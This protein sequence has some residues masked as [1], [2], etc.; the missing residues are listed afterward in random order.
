PDSTHVRH[1]MDALDFLVVQDLFLTETARYADVVLPAVSWAEKEGTFVNTERR[2]QKV[3]RALRPRG[4]AR[5][6]WQI[7]TDLANK[8]G[9]N[10]QY[11]CPEDIFREITSLTPSFAGITYD[12][13]GI[14]GI[15]WPCPTEIHP[16]TP[17]LH[18]DK[19]SRGQ[20][21]FSAVEHRD[22]A[23]LPDAEYPFMLTT[24]RILYHYHTG[25][26]TR[27]STGL[28]NVLDEELMEMHPD[29][30]K[31]LGVQECDLVKVTSRRGSVRS[32]LKI[33]ERVPRGVVF[34]TFHFHETAA[35]IL[36]SSEACPTAK[37]PELKVSA[38]RI[39]K[40]EADT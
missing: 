13:L 14:T 37:I 29:D 23:E 31:A 26:M 28:K 33:S 35:N 9:L 39:E 3:N 38:V 5:P 27:R 2:V 10:W 34:M 21:R 19:F 25:T 15:H 30:A 22:P 36:T 40:V 16:G 18:V 17:I 7:I 4:D 12:R 32:K 6:D 1:C 11:Q 20:G 8:M 24:G